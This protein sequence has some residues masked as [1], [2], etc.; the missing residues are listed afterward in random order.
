MEN[1][2]FDILH[3]WTSLWLQSQIKLIMGEKLI[4]F[5]LLEIFMSTISYTSYHFFA[6]E[7]LGQGYSSS[8]MTWMTFIRRHP[9]W[10]SSQSLDCSYKHFTC[11]T[12][13]TLSGPAEREASN[14]MMLPPP[15]FRVGNAGRRCRAVLG[16]SQMK[17]ASIRTKSS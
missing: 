3:V 8:Q 2:P 14:S 1:C 6:N 4:Y 15:G 7:D 9:G 16:W 11:S 12:I 17:K 10:D 5:F 13:K